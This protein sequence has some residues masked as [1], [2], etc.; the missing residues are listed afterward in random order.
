[1]DVKLAC[2]SSWAIAG[3][4]VFSHYMLSDHDT[5][6]VY[7]GNPWWNNRQPMI[8]KGAVLR[9]EIISCTN[10]LIIWEVRW[11]GVVCQWVTLFKFTTHVHI[12]MC[13]YIL[14]VL[15]PCCHVTVFF[16]QSNIPLFTLIQYCRSK[17]HYYDHSFTQISLGDELMMV[18]S[19]PW[20]T[21]IS[22]RCHLS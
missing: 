13:P 16:C 3:K 15:P 2:N 9:C 1:M 18:L 17:T 19:I 6:T 14:R 7:S 21:G 5:I 8:L 12:F 20:N 11:G 10:W 22:V 4:W